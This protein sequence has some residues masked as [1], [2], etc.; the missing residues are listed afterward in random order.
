MR[1]KSIQ[2]KLQGM[3]MLTSTIVL[4]LACAAFVGVELA[5]A[6]YKINHDLLSLAEIIGANSTAALTFGDR[7]AASEVL[8]ALE[9][10]PSIIA[11]AIYGNSGP[12]VATHGDINQQMQG[13]SLFG[14]LN[15]IEI[16]REIVFDGEPIGTVYIASDLRDLVT[17]LRQQAALAVGILFAS[18]LMAYLLASRLQRLISQPILELATAAA[19][20]RSQK[21]YSIRV[22]LPDS[23]A[24]AAELTELVTGFNQML[25]EIEHRDEEL[26][27]H[28]DDLE[29]QVDVRTAE[30]RS[31]NTKL[32]EAKVTAESM[33][34]LNAG[35]SRQR[36]MILNAAGEGIMGIDGAGIVTF[37]NTTGAEIVGRP[38]EQIVGV[39]LHASLHPR[40]LESVDCPMCE[41][42]SS[43]NRAVQTTCSVRLDSATIPI[44]YIA[45]PMIESEGY[46]SG[47][48]V[49]FRD[50]TERLAIERMKDEFVS[51]VSHELRTPLTSIRGAL[52]LLGSG[53]I[54]TV[55]DRAKRML[56]IAISNT[57]RLVRL[58]NDILDLERIESGK[59]ELNMTT[60]NAAEVMEEAVLVVQGIADAAGVAIFLEKV[61]A[62]VSL[63]R[64]RIVQTLTNLLGNAIKFS[65]RGAAV[66]L[67]GSVDRQ[68][69]TFRIT[70]EGR[71]VP[72]DQLDTIFERFQQVDASD[73]RDKGGSGLG[74]PI[75]RSIVAA[76]GGRIWAESV[77]GQGSVFCFTLPRP[78]GVTSP[79]DSTRTVVIWAQ[80]RD[81]NPISDLLHARGFTPVIIECLSDLMETVLTRR[82]DAVVLDLLSVSDPRWRFLEALK[83]N[84]ETEN[85]PII[86]GSSQPEVLLGRYVD[87]IA[88]WVPSPFNEREVADAVSTVSGSISVLVIED[89]LDL[90]RVMTAGLQARGIH[91]VH[92]MTGKEAI[93][94]CQREIPMLVVL[95]LVLPELDGF[96]VVEWMR[97]KRA[98]S[99]VPLLVFSAREVPGSEQG[100]LRLGPTDFLIKSRV[101]LDEFADTVMKLLNAVNP[102]REIQ[103]AS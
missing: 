25:T 22:L 27:R 47:G 99:S 54:G 102:D 95:D 56:D 46:R 76:H 7:E 49:V 82:P 57:D 20:V 100:R 29:H 77:E 5:S 55:G 14:S 59:V 32:A 101:S 31:T 40:D 53:L 41:T 94:A 78:A 45:T 48:V 62:T 21:D 74:L 24:A 86:V 81:M 70:D 88:R 36:Q 69:F 9:A 15:R 34:E 11:A 19:K 64:D 18:L 43:G 71:G 8:Q 79:S 72:V 16:A 52:G 61:D 38:V 67:S 92:A 84:E 90:A 6:R 33:A 51:T 42:R 97:T 98:L 23:K 4:L 35:L 2:R 85:V 75:C 50:I 39:S 26:S 37:I 68:N 73:S 91:T 63:D 83:K 28:R 65:P 12:P 89:D 13:S 87:L 17:A 3:I 10:K 44:E 60:V 58:I 1:E 96:E 80:D 30:L 103:N 66:R 93:E